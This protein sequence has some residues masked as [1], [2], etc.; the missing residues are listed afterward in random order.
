MTWAL[1]I[2]LL[3]IGSGIAPSHAA[4]ASRPLVARALLAL[5]GGDAHGANALAARAVA[6]DDR[7]A[8]AHA[9]LAR[10]ALALGDGITAEAELARARD[11]GFAPARMH[12][13]VAHARLLQG[14]AEGALAEAKKA[15]PRYWVYGLRI[16]AAA[17][18]AQGNPGAAA[19]IMNDAARR[20][21]DDAITWTDI[22]KLCRA[23]GDSV[24]AIEAAT[25]AVALDGNNTDALLLRGQLVATQFGLSAAL[26]W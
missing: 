12:Q 13:M 17:L 3:A 4:D 10:T 9:V 15:A 8:L 18:V 23:V 5:R 19:E 22:G 6:A 24:C 14:D 25:R 11:R 20:A 1:V 2:S 26:P 16:Q 7:S 21:P